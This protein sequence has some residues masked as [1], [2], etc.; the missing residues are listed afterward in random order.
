MR[1]PEGEIDFGAGCR[2]QIAVKNISDHSHDLDGTIDGLNFG[3]VFADWILPLESLAH[4]RLIHDANPHIAMNVLVSESPALEQWDPRRLEIGAIADTKIRVILLVAAL[5]FKA[6][7][8]V[9]ITERHTAHG[10]RGFDSR[11]CLQLLNGLMV[12]VLLLT[13]RA[14]CRQ[15]D[16]ENEQMSCIEAGINLHHADEAPD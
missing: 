6:P 11:Q 9:A 3:D 15:A 7:V 2:F 4:Q 1:L 12:E 13:G 10:A 16:I 5:D 14:G 8:A